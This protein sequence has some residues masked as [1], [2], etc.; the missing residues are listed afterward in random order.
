MWFPAQNPHGWKG[1]PW[2]C[3]I[4]RELEIC[5]SCQRCVREMGVISQRNKQPYVVLLL[6]TLCP[7]TALPKEAT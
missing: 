7:I 3:A 1:C 4:Q 5:K 6:T 2:S